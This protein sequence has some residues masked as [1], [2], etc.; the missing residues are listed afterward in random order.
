MET[1]KSQ[2]H[3][4][5]GDNEA[6]RGLGDFSVVV[7]MLGP[8]VVEMSQIKQLSGSCALLTGNTVEIRAFTITIP[9]QQEQR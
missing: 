8:V 5:T 6:G 1:E 3:S 9:R 7:E 4:T 2:A